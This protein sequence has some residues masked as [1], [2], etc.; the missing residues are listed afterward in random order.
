VSIV[1][2]CYKGEAHLARA[3]E[4]GL[5][6][7]FHALEVIVVDDK[8]PDR[9]ATIA[10]GYALRDSRL[11]VIRRETNGG[12][13]RAWNTGF[14]AANGEYMLRLAQDDRLKPSAVETMVAFLDERSDVGLTYAPMD[15]V[16]AEGSLLATFVTP[17]QGALYPRNEVGLC[18][19]WR[20]SVWERVGTFDPK[21]D[22]AEDYDYWLRVGR[23]FSIARCT[24]RPL[25][26]FLHH[27][28]QNSASGEL[29]QLANT[30]RA[31]WKQRRQDVAER[32]VSVGAWYRFVRSS[33]AYACAAARVRRE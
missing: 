23:K 13:A 2:P 30:R 4:S 25:L 20:R 11:R 9:C 29:R 10:D 1:I 21:C 14:C 31:I 12:V 8:S 7:T 6:Q 32:P 18:V 24:E 26:E 27:D 17:E 16:D 19:M 15:I 3:I 33:V 22:F 28:A 5:G